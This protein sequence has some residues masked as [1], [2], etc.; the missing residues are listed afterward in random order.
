MREGKKIINKKK[1]ILKQI[2]KT[3]KKNGRNST[4]HTI[5]SKY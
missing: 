2:K 3:N 5:Y 1:I 4:V